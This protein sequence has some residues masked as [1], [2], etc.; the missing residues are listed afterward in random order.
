[1]I[2]KTIVH[3]LTF[4]VITG[5]LYAHNCKKNMTSECRDQVFKAISSEED[6]DSIDVTQDCCYDLFTNY[7]EICFYGSFVKDFEKEYNETEI[8]DRA[9][10]V[11]FFCQK[12]ID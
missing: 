9:R 12:K 4:L 11:R 8:R 5:T 3:I 10:D 7:D 1:M 6:I 2:S